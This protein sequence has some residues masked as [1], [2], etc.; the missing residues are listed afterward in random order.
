MSGGT[1]VW[2]RP[3]RGRS[4]GG[5]PSGRPGIGYVPALDGMR[6]LAVMAVLAF[7]GGMAWARGGFLGVDAFF[8]LSG[9]LITSLL[10]AEWEQTGRIAL[11]RFWGRRARRLLPA[12]LLMVAVVTL[13][14][15]TLLPPE[16]VRLLRGDGLAALFYVANWR[17]ILR[18]G[19]YFAQTASPSPLEHTWSLGI[20]E[21]FYLVWPLLM[22]GLLAGTLAV[23]A[24]RAALAH[25]I[26][27]C[28]IGAAAS[29]VLLATLYRS[30][31]PG[32]A[33]Y[34][35]DTRGASLLVGAGLAVLLAR[36]WPDG[37]GRRPAAGPIAVGP[38]RAWCV[39]GPGGAGSRLGVEP[40]QRW[41]CPAVSRR[42]ADGGS[43]GGGSA[44]ARG[45]RAPRLVREGAGGRAPGAG[46]TD[47][48]RHLP[49]ALADVHRV[50]QRP[51]G[52]PGHRAVHVAMPGHSRGGRAVLSVGRAPHPRRRTP[53]SPMGG[54]Q[55]VSLGSPR[56]PVWAPSQ[57][58]SSRP[59][60][61]GHRDP[62][63]G[64]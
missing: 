19:D 30:D 9:Y 22:A 64:P 42:P 3:L 51:Y 24:R 15:R 45:A 20:E 38:D 37:D 54:G 8:V 17:M 62:R 25:A 48:L 50:E 47:L 61:Y 53:S 21:Q 31:D 12:L 35:T 13:G 2:V 10:L 57:L 11:G 39:R 44:G 18:G 23:A 58:W 40:C 4:D 29:T 27:L 41:R 59:R 56:S 55:R 36:R 49:V 33:Y 7:H 5:Q 52:P 16:E 1:A 14:A 43:G 6:G 63:R 28:A 34:G 46:G 60:R 32:R 26:V